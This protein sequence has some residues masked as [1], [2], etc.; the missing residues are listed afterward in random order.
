VD[1]KLQVYQVRYWRRGRAWAEEERF[2]PQ[3]ALVEQTDGGTA[4]VS[5]VA[6]PWPWRPLGSLA[7]EAFHAWQAIA[8]HSERWPPAVRGNAEKRRKLLE[9]LV[10]GQR[11]PL[12][13]RD[14][15]GE[16]LEAQV[17]WLPQEIVTLQPVGAEQR[18]RRRHAVTMQWGVGS[19][20]L[21]S[22]PV[23]YL[24]VVHSRRAGLLQPCTGCG[25]PFLALDQRR[26]IGDKRRKTCDT[27]RKLRELSLNQQRIVRRVLDRVRIH[28]RKKDAHGRWQMTADAKTQFASHRKEIKQDLKR[29]PFEDWL[30]KYDFPKTRSRGRS[31]LKHQS[32]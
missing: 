13:L 1:I 28:Y 32:E 15:L 24:S 18:G 11:L 8:S 17:Q 21:F 10:A 12:E 31:R 19:R 29:M 26:G 20:E 25:D 5:E 9:A 22:V 27:C 2:V 23:V 6:G 14:V 3:V 4:L 16:M 7:M 30:Q